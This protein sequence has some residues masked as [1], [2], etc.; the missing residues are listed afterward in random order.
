MDL[1]LLENKIINDLFQKIKVVN[2]NVVNNKHKVRSRRPKDLALLEGDR[3]WVPFQ[4]K[5]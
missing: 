1:K 2:F 5:T 3:P 4:Y